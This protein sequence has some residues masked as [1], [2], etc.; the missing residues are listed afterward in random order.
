M[1]QW[2]VSF[3]P[4]VFRCRGTSTSPSAKRPEEYIDGALVV[5]AYPSVRHERIC[6]NLLTRLDA[7]LPEGIEVF[8]GAGCQGASPCRALL[9]K[10]HGRHRSSLSPR[11]RLNP[12]TR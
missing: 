8:H 4:S 1:R 3:S 2:Q 7:I 9:K 5:S 6:R 12:H 10:L 11:R